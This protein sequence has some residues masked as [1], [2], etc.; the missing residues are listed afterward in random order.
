MSQTRQRAAFD[1]LLQQFAASA[2]QSA[3]Q[4]WRYLEAAHVLG[5]NRLGLHWRAH[6]QMLR[7]A[8]QLGDAPEARGQWARLGLTLVGHLV[9]RLPQGNIGR[10]SVPA[11]RPMVPSVAVRACIT[12]AMQATQPPGTPG[13]QEMSQIDL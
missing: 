10:A 11:L 12:E 5:Q 9:R 7:F 3:A 13:A 4:R 2:G 8:R 1:Y 6:W